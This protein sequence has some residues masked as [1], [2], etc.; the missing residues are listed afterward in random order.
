VGVADGRVAQIGGEMEAALDLDARGMLLLPGAID[1]HVHLTNPGSMGIHWV[2]DFSSGSAAALAG[3]VTTIGNITFPRG[4]GTLLAALERE[5][6]LAAAQ[7]IADVFLHPVLGSGGTVDP[8][9]LDDILRLLEHGCNSIKYFLLLPHFD[10]Q[11]GAYIEATCRAGAG[12]LI[13]MIHCEDAPLI[14]NAVARLSNE[15][16]TAVRHY[17]DAHPVLAEVVATQRAVAIAEATRAP[18]Y[19]VHLSSRRALAVCAEAQARGVPVYVEVRPFYLHLTRERFDEPDGAKYVGNPPLREQPD[20]E[21]LWRG[22]QQGS[23]HTVCTDHAPWSL[24]D[25]LDPSLTIATARPW[26]GHSQRHRTL[27]HIESPL[28]S[29]F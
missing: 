2:D 29:C 14:D 9:T 12:G 23:V 27:A 17:P 13:T 8:A 4:G 25:K 7:A 1:A 15:G 18:V 3:G 20:V 21:A 5:G 22:I 19:I 28:C 10:A 6:A 11:V 24:A 26:H 16:K